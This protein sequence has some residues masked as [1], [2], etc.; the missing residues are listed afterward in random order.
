MKED[1]R[2]SRVKRYSLKL[3]KP[4]AAGG[5]SVHQPIIDRLD[6]RIYICAVGYQT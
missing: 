2:L 1:I 5:L 4:Q 6:I 3:V